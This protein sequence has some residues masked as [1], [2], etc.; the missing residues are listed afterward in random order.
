MCTTLLFSKGVDF[1]ALNFYLDRV[2]PHQPFLKTELETLG[3]PTVK[4]ASFF[5]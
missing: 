2:V 1:F 3:Y 5:L 4:T